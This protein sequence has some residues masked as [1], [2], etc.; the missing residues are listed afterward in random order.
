[1]PETGPADYVLAPGLELSM[2]ERRL[3]QLYPAFHVMRRAH[4][5]TR[6]DLGAADEAEAERQWR[7][8]LGPTTWTNIG[9]EDG[10][11]LEMPGAKW[12]VKGYDPRVRPSVG[13]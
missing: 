11:Y 2:I 4:L 1:M 8:E 7:D 3:R 12:D 9:L 13:G 6:L 5:Q 10:I